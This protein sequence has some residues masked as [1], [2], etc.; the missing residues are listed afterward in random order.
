MHLVGPPSAG[1]GARRSCWPKLEHLRQQ[2]ERAR[3]FLAAEPQFVVV[4]SGA[5]GEPEIEGD[6]SLVDATLP[7]SSSRRTV[8]IPG[9]GFRRLAARRS[10]ARRSRPMSHR[11][12]SAAKAFAC[13]LISLG[14][15]HLEAEGR[16]IGGKRGAA[17][18]RR[19]RRPARTDAAAR[20]PSRQSAQ[21]ESLRALLD[22]SSQAG[23]DA[24]RRNSNLTWVN[25]AYAHA[26][27]AKNPARRGGPPARTARPSGAAT[28]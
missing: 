1:P 8:A 4:W 21:L 19:F 28:Q 27:E 15:R 25:A 24:R 12:A 23:L 10:G 13:D 20:K 14:G 5:R 16:A 17:H 6:V 2:A 22:L 11:C 18:A 7:E 3:A 26:V 9:A